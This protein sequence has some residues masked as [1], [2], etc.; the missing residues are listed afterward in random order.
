MRKNAP[1]T[2]LFATAIPDG[3]IK[4]KVYRGRKECEPRLFDTVQNLFDWSEITEQTEIHFRPK[5]I[6]PDLILPCEPIFYFCSQDEIAEFA[7][8]TNSGDR[9]GWL[10]KYAELIR[11]ICTEQFNIA[12]ITGNSVDL[13]DLIDNP[14]GYSTELMIRRY[15]NGEFI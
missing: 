13:T 10:E 3:R 7:G 1:V 8:L 12:C 6:V 2:K 9:A 4:A 14:K 5:G 15:E 11:A